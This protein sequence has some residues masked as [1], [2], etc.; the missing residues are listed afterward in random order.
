MNPDIKVLFVSALDLA[1]EM[2]SILPDVKLEDVIQEPVNQENFV[3]NVKA[4]L[5]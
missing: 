5:A 1:K 4:A 3:N 2:V